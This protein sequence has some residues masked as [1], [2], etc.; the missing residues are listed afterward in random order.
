MSLT[1]RTFAIGDIHGEIAHLLALWDALPAPGADDTLVFLGDYV[2]RGPESAEVVRWIREVLP[3]LTEARIV[4][5][6]GNHEDAW[7]RVLDEGFPGFVLPKGNGC[8]AC[9]RS[10]GQDPSDTEALLT[11]A[12]WPADVVTWMRALPHWYEDEHA[13]YVHAGLPRVGDRW[14]HPRD[15]RPPST[16][17]W[18]RAREFFSDYHGKPVVVGHT[19][20][21]VLPPELSGFTPEDPDD[22]W[23]RDPVWAIDTGCG[24]GG[25]LTAVE[26]PARRVWE[27]RV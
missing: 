9:M 25:F 16:L 24:R 7:I 19:A 2:D 6:R 21:N 20:T 27:S 10:Y 5:L 12:F 26:L 13:L 23:V 15:V 18:T 1:G 22:L 8:A 4:C 11:G 17:L 14:L 3:L